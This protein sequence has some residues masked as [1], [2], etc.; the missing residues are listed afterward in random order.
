MQY[1]IFPQDLP[2]GVKALAGSCAQGNECIPWRD[3]K[4]GIARRV[5]HMPLLN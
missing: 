4:P 3:G 1:D 5:I 2:T